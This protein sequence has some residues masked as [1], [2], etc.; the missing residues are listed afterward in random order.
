[1]KNITTSLFFILLCGILFSQEKNTQKIID[2]YGQVYYD[3][4]HSEAPDLLVLIDKYIEYG[5]HVKT[6]SE[7]KYAEFVPLD[8]IPLSSKAGGEVSV[9]EF[10]EDV[11]SPDF[12]PLKYKFFPG[13]D[14]QV[15]KLNGVNK[16]I[17]ILPQDSILLK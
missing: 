4:L 3:R 14:F 11:D 13:K 12:N 1:M 10:M 5:F 6:V 15:F 7:G 9:A 16:I 2:V 8:F 17:Y